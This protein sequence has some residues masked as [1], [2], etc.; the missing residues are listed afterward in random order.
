[1]ALFFTAMTI[2]TIDFETRSPVD[3][4][5]AGLHNYA[6]DP[7]TEVLCL[8]WAVDDGPV[9]IWAHGEYDPEFERDVLLHISEGLPVVAHN[10]SFELAVWN[11]VLARQYPEVGE[12]KPGQCLDTM[13]MAYALGLPGSLDK[14]SAAVGLEMEKDMAGHRLMMS[15]GKPK[16]DGTYRED[17][18]SLQRLYEYCKRDV[19][20]ERELYKRLLKLSPTEQELWVLDQKINQRGLYVDTQ[21]IKAAMQIVE[22]AQ[23]RLNSAIRKVTNGA[24]ATCTATGQLKDWLVARGVEVQGVA[25][26]DVLDA[27]SLDD[28]PPDARR[29]LEL[30]QE[31]GKSSTAKLKAMLESAGSDSR[32]RNTMQYHGAATGRWAGRRIQIQ[33][34]PRPPKY[35]EDPALQEEILAAITDGIDPELLSLMYGPPMEVLSGCLRAFI[36]AAPWP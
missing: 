23:A 4:K 33:N 36:T 35:L 6:T 21:A 31:A 7:R 15:M 20:V 16:A 27:L 2:L 1:V 29:A 12:L 34:Y 9:H 13:A 10:S 25:K 3:L 32:I 24:V 17:P 26:S 14:A 28:L 18:E 22:K 8:G 30:R 11:G 19:E 5:T